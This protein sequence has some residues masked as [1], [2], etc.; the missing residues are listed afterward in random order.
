MSTGLGD[1]YASTVA[2][3]LWATQPNV[4]VR[5]IINF[6]VDGQL[7]GGVGGIVTNNPSWTALRKP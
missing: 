4:T 1:N 7:E 5:P 3:A 6:T 2:I